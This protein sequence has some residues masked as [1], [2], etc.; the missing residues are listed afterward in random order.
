MPQIDE[1]FDEI[2]ASRVRR[3]K[4]LLQLKN[5]VIGHSDPFGIASKAAIVLSYSHWEGFYNDCVNTYTKFLKAKGGKIKDQD[6]MMLTGVMVDELQSLRD[7][8]HSNEARR[9]FVEKLYDIID[10]GYDRFRSEVV[11]AKSNLNCATLYHNLKIMSFDSTP[12][13]AYKIRLDTQV[14]AWRHAIAHGDQP[15][16]RSLDIE[17]HVKLV[18]DLMLLIADMFQDAMLK[19]L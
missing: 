9:I 6:W 4:E 11:Y 8:N 12:I 5:L 19:R 1:F 7:R 14:V 15:D 16:L 2:D 3:A 18:D 13:N 10:C 17:K